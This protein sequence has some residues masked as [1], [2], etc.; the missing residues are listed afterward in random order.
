MTEYPTGGS[1]GDPNNPPPNQPP[2]GAPQPPYGA[3]GQPPVSQSDQRL[4]SMLAHLSGF[5]LAIIGPVI[6]YVMYKD[7][8]EF[9]KDQSAEALNFQITAAIGVF[10]GY[11]IT[12]ILTFISAGLLFFLVII[13]VALA[14]AAAVFFVIGGM[15]AN[16]G[17]RYRYPFNL[18]LV[19]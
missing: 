10:G 9:L 13:P 4:W 17:E 18:R 1:A 5:V 16:R 11:I 14:I 2:Y 12:L 7:R 3:P 19:K 15:A 8:D 6:I